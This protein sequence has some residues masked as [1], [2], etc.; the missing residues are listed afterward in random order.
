[1]SRRNVTADILDRLNGFI[2]NGGALEATPD[3]MVNVL[4][5]CRAL[6]LEAS[7]AQHFHRKS[8]IKVTVNA[9][10]EAAGLKGIGARGEESAREADVRKQIAIANARAKEDG[11]LA[12]EARATVARLQARVDEL[13]RENATLRSR[14][15]AAEERMR[16]SQ[17]T[18]MLLR[19]RPSTGEDA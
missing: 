11:Q 18:G 10:A 1:M 7:D 8:E 13:T 12:L 3:G 14:L 17:E 4:A 9:L 5:L 2:A 6:G 19:I 15:A 16:F